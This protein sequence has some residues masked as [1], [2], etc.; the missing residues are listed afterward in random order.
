MSNHKFPLYAKDQS[1][2][3]AYMIIDHDKVMTIT[4]STTEIGVAITHY[5]GIDHH[6]FDAYKRGDLIKSNERDF[7]F[8]RIEMNNHLIR[9][10]KVVQPK[11]SE[12]KKSQSC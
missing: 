1:G 10:S 6:V 2:A 4:N 7:H 8:G 3:H 12:T 11:K 5:H 9:R